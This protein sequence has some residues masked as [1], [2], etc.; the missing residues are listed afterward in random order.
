MVMTV[1]R[2]IIACERGSST[3]M[4]W[5]ACPLLNSARARISTA[6]GVVR[7]PMPIRVKI[8]ATQIITIGVQWEDD[9]L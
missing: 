5:S 9:A 8:R 6:I 1:S 7:S 3:A 2:C 4:A